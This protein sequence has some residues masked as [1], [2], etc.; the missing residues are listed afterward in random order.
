M[1]K[2]F[3]F[4]S[5]FCFSLILTGCQKQ[6]PV[7]FN[8]ASEIEITCQHKDVL[9]QRNYTSQ[10]KMGAIL[11]YLR[12]MQDGKTAASNPTSLK[13]DIY[14]IRVQLSDGRQH[15]YQQTAHQYFK[16]YKRPW[17]R[18]SPEAAKGLYDI[19]SRYES[20]PDVSIVT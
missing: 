19:L 6:Q 2:L 17:I 11:L 1:K 13:K 15:I 7:P 3:V 8:L 10:E 12:L 20:D 5:L 14:N 9:I 18:V 16:S 4:L